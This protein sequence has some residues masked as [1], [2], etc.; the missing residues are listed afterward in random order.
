MKSLITETDFYHAVL[1][2]D[3]SYSSDMY[4]TSVN[5][6]QFVDNTRDADIVLYQGSEEMLKISPQGFWVRGQLVPQD[7]N[8]GT[9]VYQAIRQWAIWNRLHHVS[10]L[11]D[12]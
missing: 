11:V 8:E 1:G 12:Q 4:Y 5:D 3:T 10:V 7:S 2:A 9:A 6:I